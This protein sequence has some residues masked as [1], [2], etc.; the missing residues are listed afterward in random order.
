MSTVRRLSAGVYEE[1]AETPRRLAN[2]DD[3]AEPVDDSF[4]SESYAYP[5]RD[6][7]RPRSLPSAVAS[8]LPS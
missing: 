5:D 4:P 8:S 6:L 3:E 7:R 2:G 1:A